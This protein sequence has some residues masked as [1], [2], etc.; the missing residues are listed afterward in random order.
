MNS[1]NLRNTVC[2][3]R[4]GTY[5]IFDP[6]SIKLRHRNSTDLPNNGV[7]EGRNPD[8]MENSSDIPAYQGVEIFRLHNLGSI[9]GYR[10]TSRRTLRPHL[11][12]SSAQALRTT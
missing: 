9:L 8:P 2:R 11:T 4:G 7:L 1:P 3:M 12:L 6:S 10:I 5:R